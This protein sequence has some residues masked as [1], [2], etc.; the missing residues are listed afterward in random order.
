[1]IKHRIAILALLGTLVPLAAGAADAGSPAGHTLEITIPAQPSVDLSTA[2]PTT[3]ANLPP[4]LLDARA[5]AYMIA[6]SRS[7]TPQEVET[8]AFHTPARIEGVAKGDQGLPAC[9]KDSLK[10][11]SKSGVTCPPDPATLDFAR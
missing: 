2:S 7:I 9:L 11:S 8:A 5:A 1:M 4:L 6:I 3:L 10:T